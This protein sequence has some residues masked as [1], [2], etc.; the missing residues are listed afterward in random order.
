ML[1]Q[2]EQQRILG[3]GQALKER[4]LAAY[5]FSERRKR[6]LMRDR[7]QGD[8]E[9]GDRLAG[10]LRDVGASRRRP[11]SCLN[12]GMSQKLG[13]ERAIDLAGERSDKTERC[14]DNCAE[15]IRT[16]DRDGVIHSTCLDDDITLFQA[17][18][19]FAEPVCD[20][21]EPGRINTPI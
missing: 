19:I 14:D 17:R 15:D 2:T 7:R 8:V 18:S 21:D 3:R 1:D 4:A 12:P 10:Q 13:E 6:P 5:L 11:K 20:L 16:R 9:I